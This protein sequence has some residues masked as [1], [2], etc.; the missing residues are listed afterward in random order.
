MY[1][2]AKLSMI[3]ATQQLAKQLEGTGITV[4]TF[5]PGPVNTYI[6]RNLSDVSYPFSVAIFYMLFKVYLFKLKIYDR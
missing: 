3:F 1:C 5:C 6:G 2:H 4:N